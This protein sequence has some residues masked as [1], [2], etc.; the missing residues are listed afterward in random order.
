MEATAGYYNSFVIRIWTDKTTGFMR[1]YV[2]HTGTQDRIYFTDINRMNEFILKN[3]QEGR[4]KPSVNN[5]NLM[6]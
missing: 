5:N 6:N 1:G 2:Q 4:A 3:I